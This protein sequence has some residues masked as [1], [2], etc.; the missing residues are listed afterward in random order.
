MNNFIQPTYDLIYYSCKPVAVVQAAVDSG[1]KLVISIL[2]CNWLIGLARFGNYDSFE[3][4]HVPIVAILER[5]D[6]LCRDY[7]W[8]QMIPCID[9]S[10]GEIIT[11]SRIVSDELAFDS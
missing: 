10:I 4:F 7:F 9:Y 3:F 5:I 6:T 8:R 1:V 11:S 2:K